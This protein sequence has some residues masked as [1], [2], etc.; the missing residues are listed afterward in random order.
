MTYDLDENLLRDPLNN[1]KPNGIFGFKIGDTMVDVFSS[2]KSQGMM[3]EKDIYEKKKAI[4]YDNYSESHIVDVEIGIPE[5]I[6]RISL[7]LNRQKELDGIQVFFKQQ[8]NPNQY[9][10][11]LKDR[12][13]LLLKASPTYNFN[14]YS[15]RCG[16]YNV[17]L[18]YISAFDPGNEISLS[19]NADNY[20]Y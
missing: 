11:Q 16:K 8:I 10:M 2:I 6:S 14:I 3:S 19:F 12:L 4:D 17:N 20:S 15:W 9:F 18:S 5:E 13:S 1:V 7:V